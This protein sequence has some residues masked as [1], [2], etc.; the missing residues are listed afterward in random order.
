S[1]RYNRPLPRLVVSEYCLVQTPPTGRPNLRNIGFFE[2]LGTVVLIRLIKA[3]LLIEQVGHFIPNVYVGGPFSLSLPV[4]FFSFFV[5]TLPFQRGDLL[6]PRLRILFINLKALLGI[7]Q[8]GGIK[9]QSFENTSTL[10]INFDGF[11]IG[12]SFIAPLGDEL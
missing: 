5:T 8:C 10:L 1:Q 7:F 3:F 11:G 2:S 12:E 4:C 6:A 9:I